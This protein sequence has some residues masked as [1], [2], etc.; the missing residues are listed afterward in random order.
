MLTCQL[1]GIEMLEQKALLTTLFGQPLAELSP[2]WEGDWQVSLS[3]HPPND[4]QTS[5]QGPASCGGDEQ[6]SFG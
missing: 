3:P 5:L 4:E 1:R 6:T 2:D